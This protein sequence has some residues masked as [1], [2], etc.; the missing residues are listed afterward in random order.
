MKDKIKDRLTLCFSGI[1]FGLAGF[2]VIPD[3]VKGA[4]VGA[5][6][7][8]AGAL[9]NIQQNQRQRKLI[10]KQSEIIA[11]QQKIESLY[12]SGDEKQQLIVSIADL[13]SHFEVKTKE[14]NQKINYLTESNSK[15]SELSPDFSNLKALYK[16]TTKEFE[17]H[18][19]SRISQ[20][21]QN[22]HNEIKRVG[23]N[24]DTFPVQET[25][26]AEI[27]PQQNAKPHF[28][29]DIEDE[30]Q[31]EINSWLDARNIQ[32]QDKNYN[33]EPGIDD[34]QL[35][36]LS[37]YLGE[38]YAVLS[39]YFNKLRK[40]IGYKPI[41]TLDRN[42]TEEVSIHENFL[43]QLDNKRFL[44][45]GRVLNKFKPHEDLMI[46]SGVYDRED[47]KSF[48][49]GQWFERFI[50]CYVID[51]LD[52]ENLHYQCYRNLKVVYS[53]G[54]KSEIDLFLLI[55][56]KP[57]IIECKSGENYKEGFDKFSNQRRKVSIPIKNSIYVVLGISEKDAQDWCRDWKKHFVVSNVSTLS[58]C[59]KSGLDINNLVPPAERK[60]NDKQVSTSKL[61]TPSISSKEKLTIF[62]KKKGLNLAPEKRR[63]VIDE[64][65]ELFSSIQEPLTFNEIAKSI[66]QSLSTTSS[67]V[68][69]NQIEEILKPLKQRKYLL[70]ENG[71]PEGKMSAL[72]ASIV[73][74]NPNVL[75]RICMES[76]VHRIRTS[77]D[78]NFF[79]NDENIK[80]FEEVT[81]G[82]MPDISKMKS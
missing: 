20:L 23:S 42:K 66:R 17:D 70:N 33:N 4:F 55:E 50:Y 9:N 54:E 34:A 14:L 79:D 82:K 57:F 60:F 8:V 39:T 25:G 73:S 43:K 80:A 59:I 44:S 21:E 61:V 38:N 11:N 19:Y 53:D 29:E 6:A 31:E 74:D 75:E 5:T 47:V 26:S 63:I 48:F 81:L 58:D 68:S 51:F 76:Y 40:N 10:T 16:A 30:I 22:I 36:E 49:N 64:L 28:S 7:G 77:M 46:K 52:S 69:R 72:I 37:T 27:Y 13:K 18:I 45:F 78:E 56:D 3:Q 35:D 12:S 62:F 1:F 71:K 67:P 15:N 41:H 65:I 24:L 2:W 32:I